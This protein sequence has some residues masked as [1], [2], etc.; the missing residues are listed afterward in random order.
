V[1]VS[2]PPRWINPNHRGHTPGTHIRL[3]REQPVYN[4]EGMPF[5]PLRG[6]SF[7]VEVRSALELAYPIHTRL[8]KFETVVASRAVGLY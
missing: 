4:S 8:K 6:D 3:M 2:K 5:L 7:V 1:I